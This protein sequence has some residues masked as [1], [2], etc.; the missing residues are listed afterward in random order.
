MFGVS[1]PG[2]EMI[3]WF[4]LIANSFWILGCALALATFSYASWQ[5]SVENEKMRMVLAS[6]AYKIILYAAGALFSIGLAA[7]SDRMW[8]I[9]LWI[10]LAV[11]FAVQIGISIRQK[12]KTMD[13]SNAE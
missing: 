8:E 6:A 7:T 5:A 10:I 4:N 13:I 12:K 1:D 2:T 3:N 11:F 9:I